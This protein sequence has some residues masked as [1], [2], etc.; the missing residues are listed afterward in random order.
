MRKGKLDYLESMRFLLILAKLTI[1]D[2]V[3]IENC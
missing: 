3:S 1:E 2:Q